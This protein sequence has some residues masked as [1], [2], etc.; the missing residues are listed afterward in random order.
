MKKRVVPVLMGAFALA[1][2]GVMLTGADAY[3][4]RPGGGLIG[5]PYWNIYCLDVWDPVI[6]SNG[7][8]Y[9]NDCYALRACQFDCEPWGGY[10]Q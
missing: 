2:A 10:Y 7:Q 1:V 6:C 9:S 5:C 3:A 4:K 8:I